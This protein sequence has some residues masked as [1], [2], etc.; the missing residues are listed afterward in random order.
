MSK[1]T[2]DQVFSAYDPAQ[3]GKGNVP[4]AIKHPEWG[5]QRIGF[6]PYP[7]P[8]ATRFIFKQLR[9]TLV[10][11]NNAFL[12]QM[13]ADFVVKDLVSYSFVKK[14]VKEIGGAAAFTDMNI[15]SPWEREEVIE[16]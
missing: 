7:Y 10:Q 12:H 13:K 2:L 8:S 5:I 6:Q 15:Q 14:A 4:Q 3:Y 1:K 16:I 9:E 11:G